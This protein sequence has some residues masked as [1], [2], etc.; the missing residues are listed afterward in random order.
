MMPTSALRQ[1]LLDLR[2]AGIE[3]VMEDGVP[4]PGNTALPL[5]AE[6]LVKVPGWEGE[7]RATDLV[8]KSQVGKVTTQLAE[9]N[10]R[11]AE[12][13]AA[14]NALGDPNEFLAMGAEIF[15]ENLPWLQQGQQQTP[16]PQSGQ[17]LPPPPAPGQDPEIAALKRQL[18][19]LTEYIA[20]NDA[21]GQ[22]AQESD[23][24]SKEHPGI[25]LDAVKALAAQL[26]NQPVRLTDAAKLVAYENLR[27]ENA[28]LLVK[29]ENERM[30][31]AMPGAFDENMM[32]VVST[33]VRAANSREANEATAQMAHAMA[34]RLA[35][36]KAG[37]PAN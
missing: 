11:L 4:D 14:L 26:Q 12:Y 25:N 36:R 21:R 16:P 27:A 20:T 9:A 23:V 24:V 1:R 8:P 18:A 2:E 32:P 17:Q 33:Q 34:Q 13:E 22:I 19:Q 15:G 5:T 29:L 28:A 10:R 37:L 30:R 35:R 7:H 3:M 31:S 6:Q